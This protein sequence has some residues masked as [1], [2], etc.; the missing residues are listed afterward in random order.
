MGRDDGL[1]AQPILRRALTGP[2]MKSLP[3]HLIFAHLIKAGIASAETLAAAERS[4][5]EWA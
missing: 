4:R 2:R 3:W 1:L 5:K